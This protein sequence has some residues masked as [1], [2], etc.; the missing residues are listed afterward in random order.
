MLKSGPKNPRLDAATQL[1]LL[2]DWLQ[3][4]VREELPK[5][6]HR[7]DPALGFQ[8]SQGRLLA[9]NEREKVYFEIIRKVEELE[10]GSNPNKV[11]DFLRADELPPI[12]GEDG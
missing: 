5:L 10:S 4:Q 3:M 9:L 2:R 6:R 7:V 1:R 12:E 11:A 8:E